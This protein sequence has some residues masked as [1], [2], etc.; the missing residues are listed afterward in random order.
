MSQTT[1]IR[2]G[3][4]SRT[5]PAAM[6]ALAIA[7]SSSGW[8]MIA[9]SRRSWLG[10]SGPSLLRPLRVDRRQRAQAVQEGQR[11]ARDDGRLDR[12][13]HLGARRAVLDGAPDGVDAPS[14]LAP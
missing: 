2:A 14:R 10:I 12:A 13:Q 3:P 8:R 9:F 6:G 5:V 4:S 7:T 11:P 1:A